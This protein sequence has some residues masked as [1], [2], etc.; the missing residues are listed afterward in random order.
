MKCTMLDYI[1]VDMAIKDLSDGECDSKDLSDRECDSKDLS[2]GECGSGLRDEKDILIAKE[3]TATAVRVLGE[4][5]RSLFER[6]EEEVREEGGSFED[7]GF[8]NDCFIIALRMEAPL[9]TLLFLR[10]HVVDRFND[11]DHSWFI[12]DI[13][14]YDR[15][16]YLRESL[17]HIAGDMS[18]EYDE[19][20]AE[21]IL[22]VAIDNEKWD[23][24][25]WFKESAL[26]CIKA[27]TYKYVYK[28][29]GLD[30]LKNLF[31]IMRI[32]KP[33]RK[34][35]KGRELDEFDAYY[36]SG[37]WKSNIRGQMQRKESPYLNGIL[38]VEIPVDGAYGFIKVLD[39]M[40]NDSSIVESA[41][42][43]Y[44]K[45]TTHVSK[46][47]ALI[48]R[49]TRYRHTSPFEM[50]ELQAQIRMPLF[51]A[52][53]WL[54]HRTASVNEYS[55]RYSEVPD[56]F[57]IPELGSFRPQSKTNKQGRELEPLPAE[58]A[59]WIR[60]TMKEDCEK[61]HENYQK[62]L[63]EDLSRE[64]A[65]I[66]L[67]LNT[68]TEVIWKMD[69]H[70]LFNF[71]RLRADATAQDETRKYAESILEI[72]RGWVPLACEAFIDFEMEGIRLSRTQS[73]V[74]RRMLKGEIV[75]HK[76]SGLSKSEWTDLVIKLE[77]DP[78]SDP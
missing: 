37:I 74:I 2:D 73:D 48:R 35:L 72:V 36:A 44:G 51:V 27:P 26:F 43:S 69:L 68:Y 22:E 5:S 65:R 71:I 15:L 21:K 63:A 70:N 9:D 4:Q 62:Y 23:I 10:E 75:T 17:E 29:F 54:R 28:Q 7:G 12:I 40:G 18:Q 49:L 60:T 34:L 64:L 20:N 53:H 58:K 41:R 56:L 67:P 19:E 8:I 25:Q 46:D 14:R 55:A 42:L 59:E 1:L 78:A 33:I 3:L 16:D 50:C 13:V 47:K 30:G 32:R 66:T 77:L 52:R 24:I 39:Y 57:F 61:L 76:T 38:G 6:I 45:G 31:K 11:G